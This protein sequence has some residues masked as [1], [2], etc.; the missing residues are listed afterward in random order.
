MKNK[1]LKDILKEAHGART[2][3]ASL[4][5][6]QTDEIF[7]EAHVRLAG[8]T[9]RGAG[10]R[11]WPGLA[12]SAAILGI[13][14]CLIVAVSYRSGASSAETSARSEI[15]RLQ[16]EL[17]KTKGVREEFARLVKRYGREKIARMAHSNIDY[18][19][20]ILIAEE[21]YVQNIGNFRSELV[22]AIR[23]EGGGEEGAPQNGRL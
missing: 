8:E 4:R 19:T 6:E 17:E 3:A 12:V 9:P 18:E 10:R 21:N 16:A 1:D 13:A 7:R 22:A 23:R 2:A 20:A 5:P 15:A 14:A 11:A